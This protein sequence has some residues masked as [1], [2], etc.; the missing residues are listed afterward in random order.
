MGQYYRPC[1]LATNFKENNEKPVIATA[2]CYFYG[3]GAK[4]LEHGYVG[5][6]FVAAACTFL[7]GNKTFP[8]VW[9]GDYADAPSEIYTAEKLGKEYDNNMYNYACKDDFDTKYSQDVIGEMT[10]A[11]Y[12]ELEPKMKYII[13]HSKKEYVVIP[14]YKKGK[15]T[16]HPLPLLT[17]DGC[18]RGGGDYQESYPDADKV[19]LWAYDIIEVSDEIPE[20]YTEFKVKFK[21]K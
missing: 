5:N 4:M 3:S 15:W 19:G 21:E 20:D 12:A 1:L 8:F 17:A 9:C 6:W 11:R 18:F 14:E 7:F 16:I 2:D 10:E 13:N